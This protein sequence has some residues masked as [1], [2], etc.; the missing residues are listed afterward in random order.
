M[1]FFILNRKMFYTLGC[2]TLLLLIAAVN[3]F[4]T[5]QTATEKENIPIYCV[6]TEEKKIAITFDSAWDD[7]DLSDILKSLKD[8]DCKATFFVVGDFVEKYS[9]RVEEMS[10]AGHEIANHS[11]THPHP[12]ALSREEMIKEMDGCDEKIKKI[13]GQKQVLF[14][15]PYGEYNN[16]LVQT[17]KDTGRFCI[18]WD[19]DSLDW[20]GL[21][22]DEIVKRVTEKVKN[23]SIILLHNGAENTAEAMLTLL[24][25]LKNMGY[26]FVTVS[27]LIYKDN[28][29]IDHTGM[30]VPK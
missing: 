3:S 16:L 26:E 29:Y 24:C 23:G 10:K 6:K 15:A 18:Q 8:Y 9:A 19:C 22:S 11:D 5:V 1:H 17:C 2:L 25:E 12:N 21:T 7:E 4:G 20:K 14:R 27:D 13:T 30:Q 28:Y